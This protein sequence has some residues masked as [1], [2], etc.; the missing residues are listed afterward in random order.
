MA[1]TRFGLGRLYVP[2]VR[3]ARYPMRAIL[4]P[5][6]TT[7]RSQFWAVGPILDQGTTPQCVGYCAKQFLQTAPTVTLDGPSATELYHMAQA[8]DEWPGE[9]YDGS[10]VRG[11]AKALQ[12]LGRL[13]SYVWAANAIDVRDWV[14]THG[15]VMFGTLWFDAMFKPCTGWLCGLFGKRYVLSVKGK[16][17]GG[18]AYLVTGY[19]AKKDRF[20]I[21]NSW[22]PTW[23]NKGRAWLKFAD[24]ERLLVAHQ[25]EACAAVEQAVAPVLAPV[26]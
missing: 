8:R 7:G 9:N 13:A 10:S 6:T 21:T 18:H 19:D 12:D 1:N 24:A 11:V 5:Q 25:G 4:G 15:P 26:S 2:D 20:E 22:G 14:V 16:V 23:A 3:D 17:A